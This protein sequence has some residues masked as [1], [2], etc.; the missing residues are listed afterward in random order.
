[1]N[2][3]KILTCLRH[4]N[5]VSL[6][7]CTSRRS[8]ELLLVYE[9]IPNGTVADHLHGERAKEAPL[10][11]PIR[12]SIAIETAN[13]LAYLHKKDII[14]R[15]VKT[16]NILLDNNFCVK[17]ADFGLSRLFPN[18]VTHISTAP[19]GT[20][21]YV[22]PEY[23]Q[24]YQLTDKSDVYSF[25]VVLTELISSMPAVDITR[26]RHEINLANLAMS[27]IQRCAFD[28]LIDSSLGYNSDG[29][30]TRMTTS[31]AELA[32]RCL[33]LEKDLRPSME[34]VLDTLKDIKAGEDCKF[35]M[36]KGVNDD[37]MLL[38][39]KGFQS[40][41]VAVT[42]VWA[43]SGSTTATESKCQNSF[44]CSNLGSL[45]FPL[46]NDPNCGLFLVNCAS[47][48][49][50]I[51]F[52]PERPPY[53]ILQKLST[54]K[55]TVLDEFL[56]RHLRDRA[57]I[58]FAFGNSSIPHSPFSSFAMS[59]ALT[60]FSCSNFID[61]DDKQKVQDYF[62]SYRNY[63]DCEVFT[64]YYIDQHN[65]VPT[66]VPRFCSIVQIPRKPVPSSGDLLQQFSPEFD[67]EWHVSPECLSC[68]RKGRKCA[69]S[70]DNGIHCE[71][72]AGSAVFLG[73][74]FVFSC[75]ICH[76]RKRING[77]Y[78]LSRNISSDPSSKSDIEGGSLFFGIPIF[79]YTELEEATNNFD[80]SRELG[81][82]GFGTVYYVK[83]RDGR[84]VA[85][86]HLYEHN[87]R[88]VEQFMNEIKILT[89]LR[90]PNLVSLYGCNSR[91]SQELLLVYEY[92]P[93]GTV[94]DH[95][96][97]E[98]AKEAPLA[99]PIRISIAI[100][101]ASALAYL[102]KKDIIHRDVKTNNIL[103]DNNF[104]V[105]VTDFGLS[106]LFPSDVTHISTAPQGTPEYVDPEYHQCYQLTD[107]SDVYS[108]G[109][110]LI[111][112]ISS[113]PAVDITRHRHEINLANLAVN[114]IQRCAFDELIDS[115]LGYDS[116]GEVTRMTTSVA[117][118]AFRCLQLEKNLRPSM[119]EVLDTLKDIQAGEDCKFGEVKGANSNFNMHRKIPPSPESD[120]AML[121]KNKRFQSSPV[122]VTDV[123][124]SNGSTT[125]S[126]IG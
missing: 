26:H 94:A 87:C 78:L 92:I 67:L 37:A 108:F 25:G 45:E 30:V 117:E 79:S 35:E 69:V 41:P 106:R 85:I 53:F 110:V 32:F 66:D 68:H 34:E 47:S 89:C 76:R 88:R 24:C 7:G 77:T 59:P 114:R 22:D 6:Y 28:E 126:S 91:R 74:C 113:M 96:H 125:A 64:L 100:E 40:S 120:D 104:C 27:R 65:N 99:W 54:N 15:D 95:L 63:T 56:L 14:H 52:E 107:K 10:A 82:G 122:A 73:L 4:P 36:I 58:C 86:K 116:D 105:K 101:T 49:P 50:T 115:S 44:N 12:M 20:P 119:E 29:E 93:N 9:Y 18:D 102:H 123:W 111:E 97:G 48:V 118:L 98:R 46:S 81:D 19:Q 109:V 1:M 72:I 55:F 42:D 103:L 23:H 31:V 90:H 8:R 124:A 84:E 121:L 5:L 3:I 80:S 38:K 33:Q 39:N 21:G 2:E 57:A 51:Q 17:V 112:L 71:A 75:V 83:L 43:S 62:K 11:W 61:H 70:K 60:I 16:N 13:A